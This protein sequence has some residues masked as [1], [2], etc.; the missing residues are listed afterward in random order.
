MILADV[1]IGTAARQSGV[2]IPTIRY[3]EQ[4][5]LL[6][7]PPRTDANR[8]LYDHAEIRRLTF[9]RHAREL[10][11]DVDAIRKLLS[12]QD[13]PGQ[14]CN[15]ADGIAQERLADVERRIKSLKALRAELK[16]MMADG[17]HGVVAE[18]SVIEALA[19]HARSIAPHA[20]PDRIAGKVGKATTGKAPASSRPTP[21]RTPLR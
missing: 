17:A 8:R 14:P 4:I 5:G 2:K 1:P 16:R 10:G 7:P 11:F 18:C 21:I 19:D 15:T 12:L 3:Y 9:I 6:P 13:D 20:P